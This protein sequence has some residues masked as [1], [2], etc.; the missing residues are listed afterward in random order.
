MASSVVSESC[1]GA[2][3]QQQLCDYQA[4]SPDE[5]ALVKWT[6]MV[7]HTHTETYTHTHTHRQTN[8]HSYVLHTWECVYEYTLPGTLIHT[9]PKL[10]YTHAFSHIPH[11]HAHTCMRNSMAPH[12]ARVVGYGPSPYV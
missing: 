5:V 10:P 3:P 9:H 8:P 7:M 12:W 6:D 2:V 4:A 11:S 1:G